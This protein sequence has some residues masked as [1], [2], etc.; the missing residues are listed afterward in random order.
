MELAEISYLVVMK[1]SRA[2][3]S[4][5]FILLNEEANPVLTF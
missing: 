1:I 2:R 4:H 3:I 5:K